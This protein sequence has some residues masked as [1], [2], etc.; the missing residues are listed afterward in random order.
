MFAMDGKRK[1]DTDAIVATAMEEEEGRKKQKKG[2][3]PGQQGKTTSLYAA[4]T[5]APVMRLS[6]CRVPMQVCQRKD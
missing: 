4:S 6:Q 5:R 3:A 1:L 2:T